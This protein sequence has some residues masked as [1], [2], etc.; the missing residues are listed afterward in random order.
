MVGVDIAFPKQPE[1]RDELF[2]E[3]HAN[4][5]D[6][7]SHEFCGMT[8]EDFTAWLEKADTTFAELAPL[9]KI[10]RHKRDLGCMDAYIVSQC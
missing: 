5:V 10:A 2:R 9:L 3:M 6:S 1:K 7:G 8:I 4:L